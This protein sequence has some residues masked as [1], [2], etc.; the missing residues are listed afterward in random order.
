MLIKQHECYFVA[1]PKGTTLSNIAHATHGIIDLLQHFADE[2]EMR[3]EHEYWLLELLR[4]LMPTPDQMD[5]I[6]RN[7]NVSVF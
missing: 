6:E 2:N 3:N 7:C 4:N 5:S 1:L